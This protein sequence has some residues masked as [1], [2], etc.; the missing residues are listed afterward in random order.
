MVCKGVLGLNLG[1]QEMKVGKFRPKKDPLSLQR[2]NEITQWTETTPRA[3]MGGRHVLK[4][5]EPQEGGGLSP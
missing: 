3:T 4:T 5:A 2:H 1:F